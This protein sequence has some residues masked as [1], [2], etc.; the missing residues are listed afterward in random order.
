MGE[1]NWPLNAT[2]RL[3]PPLDGNWTIFWH[4]EKYLRQNACAGGARQ[5]AG[6]YSRCQDAASPAAW[7]KTQPSSG[8]IPVA[9][10][11]T[12]FR[13]AMNQ[14]EARHVISWRLG[15]HWTVSRRLAWSPGDLCPV[16]PFLQARSV[17]PTVL[18]KCWLTQ[19]FNP[20]T[21]FDILKISL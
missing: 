13:M 10:A 7:T 11:D 18:V 1:G 16:I 20:C 21:E 6:A 17:V 19:E 9:L 8:L 3:A 14:Q 4:Q 12:Y 15:C 5:K 2:C